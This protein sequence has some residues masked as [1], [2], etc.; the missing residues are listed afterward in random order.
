LNVVHNPQGD[1]V[2]V[3]KG[4]SF[5]RHLT[6]KQTANAQ[7]IY[8]LLTSDPTYGAEAKFLLDRMDYNGTGADYLHRLV[9]QSMGSLPGDPIYYSKVANGY[10]YIEPGGTDAQT[11][12]WAMNGLREW[13]ADGSVSADDVNKTGQA[14][15]NDTYFTIIA[16]QYARSFYWTVDP[17]TLP[18]DETLTKPKPKA[19]PAYTGTVSPN[20]VANAAV[21]SLSQ[22]F[23][24]LYLFSK[25]SSPTGSLGD[26]SKMYPAS[27]YLSLVGDYTHNDLLTQYLYIFTNRVDTLAHGGTI[28]E[29]NIPSAGMNLDYYEK[30]TT[31]PTNQE[32]NTSP[33]TTAPYTGTWPDEDQLHHFVGYLFTGA[34]FQ[35]SPFTN[36]QKYLIQALKATGDYYVRLAPNAPLTLANTGDYDLGVVGWDL[37]VAY[38]KNPSD[39]TQTITT[40]LTDSF[41]Q[42]NALDGRGTNLP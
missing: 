40:Y 35:L 13:A 21:V 4:G 11:K 17:H 37:G 24:F 18:W 34:L 7:S 6:A 28:Y 22:T 20:A 2:L 26:T 25:A 5:H 19:H 39:I 31:D 15:Q 8:N 3:T 9:F 12:D 23:S 32:H 16:R 27:L 38:E 36:E 33:S 14:L 42:V 30:D 1:G 29:V 41:A 10:I